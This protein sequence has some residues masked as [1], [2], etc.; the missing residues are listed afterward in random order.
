MRPLK[1]ALE[2]GA[3]ACTKKKK[4]KKERLHCLDDFEQSNNTA[5]LV[6]NTNTKARCT[7][8]DETPPRPGTRPV[9]AAQFA[10]KTRRSTG[11]NSSSSSLYL[12]ESA[13]NPCYPPNEFAGPEEERKGPTEHRRLYLGRTVSLSFPLPPLIAIRR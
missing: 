3:T 11:L 10:E 8:D 1:N 5:M 12:G 2:T 13:S 6:P 7:G 9:D 4:K